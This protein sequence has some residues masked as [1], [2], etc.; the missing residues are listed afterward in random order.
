LV[1]KIKTKLEAGKTN[2]KTEIEFKKIQKAGKEIGSKPRYT[3]GFWKD[4]TITKV[5]SKLT[6]KP[7]YVPGSWKGTKKLE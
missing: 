4:T 6:C 1:K 7:R 5:L 3:P 2:K